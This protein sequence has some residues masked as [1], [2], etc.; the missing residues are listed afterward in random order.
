MG[1]GGLC[2]CVCEG[3]GGGQ[4]TV[5]TVSCPLITPVQSETF[6]CVRE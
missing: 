5:G 4:D 6:Q 1:V 2:A 3:G